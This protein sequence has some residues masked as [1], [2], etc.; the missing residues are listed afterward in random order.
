MRRWRPER[1]EKGSER[2]ETLLEIIIAITIL[3]VCVVALGSGIA[4]SVTISAVHRDQATAQDS[5]HNYAEAL[6]NS[7]VACTAATT[8]NYTGA[9][10]VPPGFS[11]PTVVVDY[12]L[13]VTA[14]F[15]TDQICPAG[16]DP[17]LQ[18]I[19]LT[20]VSTTGKVSQSVVV[21]VRSQS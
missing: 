9:L 3:G 5:L 19:R 14:T 2:G 4:L 13:P 12:W 10:V 16:G 1:A 21:D 17:G 7:Y 18:Q 15:T 11:T 20:L 6:Q 8:P